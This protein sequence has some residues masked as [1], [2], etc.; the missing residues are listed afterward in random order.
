MQI[1]RYAEAMLTPNGRLPRSPFV[2][3]VAGC[4]L[5]FM[6]LQFRAGKSAGSLMSVEVALLLSMMWSMFCLVSRRMHDLGKGSAVAFVL[7][8]VAAVS[9]LATLD[10]SLLGDTTDIRASMQF[11]LETAWSAAHF[12]FGFIVFKLFRREGE[13]GENSFGPPFQDGSPVP[14]PAAGPSAEGDGAW[15]AAV[16][17]RM[18]QEAA[19]ASGGTAAGHR[20]SP[21][22][23]PGRRQGTFGR[24]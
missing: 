2:V 9:F 12:V 23:A 6:V 17:R 20:R 22:G 15:M 19:A 7:L 3:L 24:R 1:A 18:M 10:Q 21:A 4:G 5:V 14:A 16:E 13:A 8:I 11:A